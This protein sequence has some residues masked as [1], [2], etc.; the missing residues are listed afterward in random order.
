MIKYLVILSALLFFSCEN[1]T[2]PEPEP[3]L[4]NI[5]DWKTISGT[6]SFADGILTQS[7]ANQPEHALGYQLSTDK[8][9]WQNYS[10]S[11]DFKS[12]LMNWVGFFFAFT[13][14]YNFNLLLLRNGICEH[15]NNSGTTRNYTTIKSF[16]ASFSTNTW[17]SLRANRIGNDIQLYINDTLV[18]TDTLSYSQKRD[19]ALGGKGP[20]DFKNIVIR[21]L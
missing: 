16:N 9:T 14:E 18:F 2:N 1:V 3:Y 12:A 8:I 21:K 4:F 13:D 7:A 5:N 20:M 10:I 19:M 17:Y 6:W 15:G 11:F